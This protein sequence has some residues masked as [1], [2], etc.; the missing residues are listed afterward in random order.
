[1]MVK[2]TPGE[3]LSGIHRELRAQVLAVLPAGAP[4]RQLRAALH[5]IDLVARTWDLQLPYAEADNADLEQTLAELRRLSGL[6]G[7]GG[8]HGAGGA[9][10]AGSAAD[11]GA[12]GGAPGTDGQSWPPPDGVTDPALSAALAR[13]LELQSELSAFQD[14]WRASGRTDPAVGSALLGLHRRMT[15]RAALAS[16][17]DD[18]SRE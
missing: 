9:A 2:P 17:A 7:S 1:M 10:D 3:L 5:C 11:G 18:Q 8:V 12:G 4:A 14:W 13:N 16:G 6:P 15:A